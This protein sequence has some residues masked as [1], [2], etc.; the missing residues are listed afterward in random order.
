MTALVRDGFFPTILLLDSGFLL[1]AGGLIA[2]TSS[3]FPSKIREYIFHSHEEW[4]QERHR[5]GEKGA[6]LYI[7]TGIVLFLES[8]ASTGLAL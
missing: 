5:K 8:L 1:L 6:N 3:I 2:M 7:L 4:S